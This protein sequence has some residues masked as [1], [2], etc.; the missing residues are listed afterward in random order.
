MAKKKLFG[1]KKV[2][3]MAKDAS[4]R[5]DQYVKETGRVGVGISYGVLLHT[6]DKLTDVLQPEDVTVAVEMLAKE[7]RGFLEEADEAFEKLVG[8]ANQVGGK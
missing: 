5:V 8:T 2:K 7:L 1:D 6:L 4:A 3:E